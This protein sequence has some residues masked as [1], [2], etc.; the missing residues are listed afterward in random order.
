MRPA[1]QTKA[2]D[3]QSDAPESACPAGQD[4]LIVLGR[5]VRGCRERARLNPSDLAASTGIEATRI[6]ALEDGQLDPDL[7]L[8]LT[9]A[10]AIGVRPSAFFIRA[11]E[12]GRGQ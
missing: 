12:L 1:S 11:E 7:D 6:L 5:A 2:P 9:L 3:L 8:L 4:R 10:E